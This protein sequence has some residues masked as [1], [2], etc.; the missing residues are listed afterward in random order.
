MRIEL[1]TKN[2]LNLSGE[3]KS[4]GSIIELRI[5]RPTAELVQALQQ[6]RINF[7]IH[8]KLSYST[9]YVFV[10]ISADKVESYEIKEE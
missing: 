6:H 2:G 9:D 1:A 5:Y 4:G 8:A 3:L 7:S 10:C